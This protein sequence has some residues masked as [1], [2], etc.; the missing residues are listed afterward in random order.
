MKLINHTKISEDILERA[1]L[2]AARSLRK[3]V[4]TSQVVVYVGLTRSWHSRGI[5]YSASKV[6]WDK[7]W[8]KVNGAFRIWLNPDKNKALV[9]AEDFF[10]TAQHEWGHI[11]DY[12]SKKLLEWSQ[13]KNGRRPLHDY[14]PEEKRADEYVKTARPKDQYADTILNLAIEI[15]TQK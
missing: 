8:R 15:E 11:S 6:L 4:N 3:R 14:R 9:R 12:Q 2:D 1:L 7:K 13:R 10:S 5:A